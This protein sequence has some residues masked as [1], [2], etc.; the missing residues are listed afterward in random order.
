MQKANK[1][2]KM[3]SASNVLT[4]GAFHCSSVVINLYELSWSFSSD[5][6]QYCY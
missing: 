3:F 5:S 4:L 6:F 1:G 2:L